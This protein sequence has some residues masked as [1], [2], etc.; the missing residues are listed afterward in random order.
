[1]DRFSLFP[2]VSEH[3]VVAIKLDEL[4]LHFFVT[5]EG[6]HGGISQGKLPFI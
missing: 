5:F 3:G 2:V 1:M 4:M 6:C